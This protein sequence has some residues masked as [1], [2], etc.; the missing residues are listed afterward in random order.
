MGRLSRLSAALAFALM[1]CSA[2]DGQLALRAGGGMIVDGSQPGGHASLVLPFSDKPA[3]LMVAAEYY[4]KNGITTIPFSARGLYNLNVGAQ[5]DIY[6]GIGSGLI[7]TKTD[8]GV[9][10]ASSTKMLFSAV[11]GLK[12]NMNEVL[13][14]FGEVSMERA[15]TSGADN[16]LAAKVGIA[17]TVSE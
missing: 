12:I 14:L 1:T 3:G 5:A 7:Y 15:L 10:S 2:A 4:K 11:S 13:G 16:N 6:L 9:A 17:L 8:L